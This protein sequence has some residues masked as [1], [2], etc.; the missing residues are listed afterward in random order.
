MLIPNSLLS[1]LVRTHCYRASIGRIKRPVYARQYPVKL[2][3]PDV[4]ILFLI[5][6][7]LFLFLVDLWV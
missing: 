7:F 5:I 3:K 2:V 1:T 4:C 6:N